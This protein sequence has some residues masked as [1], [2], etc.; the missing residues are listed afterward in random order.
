MNATSVI[1]QYGRSIGQ[2]TVF[3]NHLGSKEDAQE[4]FLEVV[5]VHN[6]EK[7]RY[8]EL[9]IYM[10]NSYVNVE[11]HCPRTLSAA[12]NVLVNCEGG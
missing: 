7:V 11:D 3:A 4:N 8:P 5:L 12:L 10:H 6:S 1:T 2:D 9:K